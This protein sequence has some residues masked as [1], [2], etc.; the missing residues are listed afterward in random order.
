[1]T[2]HATHFAAGET[3]SHALPARG[4]F[5]R[6]LRAYVWDMLLL[7]AIF[8]ALVYGI[9]SYGLYEPHEGHFAGVAREMVLGHDWVTPRLNGSAYL[10][11]PPLFYWLIA[12]SYSVFGI[13]EWAARFPQALIGWAGV[14]LA[15]V[16]ARELWGAAAGRAA[17]G[18]LGIS[19]GWY[20]FSHQ[21]LIDEMLCMLHL[22]SLYFLWKGIARP[23]R[24]RH[25]VCFYATLGLS[26]MAK[27]L[28]GFALPMLVLAVFAAARKDRA[29]LW[30]CRPA[31]GFAIIAVLVAPWVIL[32]EMRNPGFLKY[33]LIN[34]HWNRIFDKRDPPDYNASKCSMFTFLLIALIWLAPWCFFLPQIVSF[35]WRNRMR[36][37]LEGVARA[38]SDAVAIL[39][40]GALLP[41]LLFVPVPSRLIYYSLPTLPPFAVIAAG[42]WASMDTAAL[43]FGRRAAGVTALLAGV[44]I[45]IAGQFA[46]GMIRGIPDLVAA[47]GT[48]THMPG[49][50]LEIGIGMSLCGALLLANKTGVALLAL[51]VPIGIGEALNT[52]GFAAFD[53]VR[54]SK[55]M[56][57]ELNEKVGKDC[58]WISEGSL[59]IGAPA[60]TAFY[61]KTDDKG[62]A[63]FVYVM[64][65]NSPYRRPPSFPGPAPEYLIDQDELKAK[66]SS[67]TPALYVTDLM[68]T[69]D[70]SDD[71]IGLPPTPQHEV[72]VEGAG[73]RRVFAN[74]AAWRLLEKK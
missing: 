31:L 45:G 26:I 51:C 12:A 25:W 43:A 19:A 58:V 55:R 74:E 30:R 56:V 8:A 2:D 65:S 10:N 70:R 28:I 18:I 62:N 37:G 54:S 27:G 35:A 6:V 32:A 16:W 23:E 22:A 21:L 5:V 53:P 15:L 24:T 64:K 72:K 9:G 17:A 68:R 50:A 63:R 49:F 66:W 11:K 69:S 3:D 1:M 29:L 33:V 61:L 67:S 57:A 46:G 14:I 36:T 34:E 48:L 41:T 42:W 47:P 20:L 4:A 39:S 59:E 7:A 44:A 40:L 73:H 60:G 13:S 38:R 71:P 52:A